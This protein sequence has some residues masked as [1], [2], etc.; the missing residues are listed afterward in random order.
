M[1]SR[2]KIKKSRDILE[3]TALDYFDKLNPP[4]YLIFEN[5]SQP[6]PTLKKIAI[7]FPIAV[8]FTDNSVNLFLEHFEIIQTYKMTLQDHE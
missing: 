3:I 7:I 4:C 6:C 1:S 8:N 2:V 5:F